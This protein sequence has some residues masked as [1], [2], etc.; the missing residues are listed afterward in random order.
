[1][2]GETGC[3]RV[4]VSLDDVLAFDVG[5]GMVDAFVRRGIVANDFVPKQMR[6][7]KAIVDVVLAVVANVRSR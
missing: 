2:D 4:S 5:S 6:V 1:M 3:W 7:G